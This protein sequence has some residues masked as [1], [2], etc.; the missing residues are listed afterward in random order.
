MKSVLLSCS[1][2]LVSYSTVS[3]TVSHRLTFI[4]ALPL[5]MRPTDGFRLHPVFFM[6]PETKGTFTLS[7]NGKPSKSLTRCIVVY[8]TGLSLEE[9]DELYALKIKPW[10]SSKWTPPNR[11]DEIPEVN[12]KGEI[13]HRERRKAPPMMMGH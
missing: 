6:L 13:V 8:C 11:R 9:I 7:Q 5:C 1:S 2:S 3:S 4:T 12:D 10:R